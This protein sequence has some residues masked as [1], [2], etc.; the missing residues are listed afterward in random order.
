PDGTLHI[1]P[2]PDANGVVTLTVHGYDTGGT[3]FGGTDKGPVRTSRVRILSV[4]DPPMFLAGGPVTVAEDAT[5]DGYTVAKWASGMMVGPPTAKDEAGQALAFEVSGYPDGLFR[6]PPTLDTAGTLR[7]AANRDACTPEPVP[8][9]VQLRDDGGIANGGQ[10]HAP[11]ATLLLEVTCT[12]DAP[13]AVAD[14][15]EVPH[16]QPTLLPVTQ[17]D[18]DA[19]GD[20]LTVVAST[21]RATPAGP[22]VQYD[23]AGFTGLDKFQYTVDDGRGGR[24]T[25]TVEVTVSCPHLRARPTVFPMAEDSQ[26]EVAKPGFLAGSTVP[27]GA[28]VTILEAPEGMLAFEPDGSFRYRPPQDFHGTVS[29]VFEVSDGSCRSGARATIEVADVNDP[30]VAKPDVFR[31][32]G[33]DAR[34]LDVLANDSGGTDGDT[35]ALVAVQQGHQGKATIEGSKVRYVPNPG[36]RGQDRFWYTIRDPGGLEAM[37]HVDVELDAVPRVVAAIPDSYTALPDTVLRV[38]AGEGVLA[39][40]VAGDATLR[41]SVVET[42]QRGRLQLDADGGFTYQPDAGFRGEDRFLYSNGVDHA[43]VRLAVMTAGPPVADFTYEATSVVAGAPVTFVDRS[44]S[45]DGPLRSWRWDFGDGGGSTAKDPQHVFQAPGEHIVLLTVMDSHGREASTT[46]RVFVLDQVA[47]GSPSQQG[48]GSSGVVDAGPDL[49]VT[50]GDVVTLQG[51]AEGVFGL[52]WSQMAG[53]PVLLSDAAVARPTFVAGDAGTLEFRLE[54]HDRTLSPLVDTMQVL[55]LPR[56]GAVT[57]GE[58]LEARLVWR[59]V[60]GP[61]VLLTP[62][63]GAVSFTVPSQPG[64]A[65]VLE[66]SVDG[67]ADTVRVRIVPERGFSYERVGERYVFQAHVP[68]PQ[69]WQFGDGGIVESKDPAQRFPPGTH[70]VRLTVET[71]SG[72]MVFEETVRTV[73]VQARPAPTGTAS[74]P[75]VLMGGATAF[76]VAVAACVMLLWRRR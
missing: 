50:S 66:A 6:V 31:V 64:H 45:P 20:P 32:K 28:S 12:Q 59:Q 70:T 69:T 1:E 52:R 61:L 39:N 35:F 33:G 67:F 53:S 41:A 75:V 55:V 43:E 10:D 49:R 37:T 72:P 63:P 47:T 9:K 15:F 38:Q 34:L 26:L 7:F 25:A 4:N 2:H 29:F 17:N 71:P 30:P 5:T 16:D 13:V 22:H 46:K 60:S 23:P 54:G 3:A 68:G 76:A 51:H 73:G 40:D 44:R 62:E 24:S 21:G 36:A 58:D 42:T 11:P 57:L 14:R 48:G 8:V 27:P 74:T 18:R 56:D 65:F 19:D